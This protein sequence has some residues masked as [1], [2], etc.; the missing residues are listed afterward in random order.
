MRVGHELRQQLRDRLAAFAPQEVI[1]DQ[2]LRQAAVA[3]VVVGEPD[4]PASLLLTRRPLDVPRHP[5]QYA[6]PGGRLEAGESASEGARR[7]LEEELGLPSSPQDELGTLD[8][9]V[10]RSGWRIRPI[11]LYCPS[12]PPLR[13]D[14]REVARVHHVPLK[15]LAEDVA[16]EEATGDPSRPILWLEVLGDR[17]FAPTAAMM[18]Q[19]R[20]VCLFGRA[21]RVAHYEQPRF[22]W[23]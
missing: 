14:P 10:T 19:F 13:P 8:D 16:R 11:V 18:F 5:G 22:A 17:V 9:F 3:L 1:S 20:E 6:L 23:R 15:E 2:P 4:R 12:P 7:E 21:T